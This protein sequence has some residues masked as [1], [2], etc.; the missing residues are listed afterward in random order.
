MSKLE[1]EN[2]L[3]Q[4]PD[5]EKAELAFLLLRH[6]A[7]KRKA[8]LEKELDELKEKEEI[9]Q[10]HLELIERK[11]QQFMPEYERINRYVK[12]LEYGQS[13]VRKRLQNIRD[14]ISLT[15]G[16]FKNYITRLENIL[17]TA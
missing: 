10:G 6:V 15:E 17:K 11:I 2:V 5:D 12:S 16:K 9:L 13:V 1:L 3:A 8:E 14:K 7:E 4:I